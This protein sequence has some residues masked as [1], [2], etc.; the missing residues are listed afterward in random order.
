LGELS[1]GCH[2]LAKLFGGIA[3]GSFLV[4][5]GFV[6]LVSGLLLEVGGGTSNT[7]SKVQDRTLKAGGHKWNAIG[8]ERKINNMI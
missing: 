3:G 1:G 4:T 6:R 2:N 5:Q 7:G 8:P